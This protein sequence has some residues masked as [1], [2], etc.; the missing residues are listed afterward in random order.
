MVLTGLIV[1]ELR[2]KRCKM[3]DLDFMVNSIKPFATDDSLSVY[4]M[5]GKLVNKINEVV[6]AFNGE[7]ADQI[8]KE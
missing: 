7:V 6:K 2:Y 8:A 5:L 4:E 1:T 3:K